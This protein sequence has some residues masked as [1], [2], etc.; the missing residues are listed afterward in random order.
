LIKVGAGEDISITYDIYIFDYQNV[1]EL[2]NGSKPV[3]L[4][5][6]PYRFQEYYYKF[7]ITWSDDGD[8]ATYNT[9]KFYIYN[10]EESGA[11]L[12][13]SDRLTIPYVTILGFEWLLRALPVEVNDLIDTVLAT[14]V[15]GPIEANL[16]E[17]YDS[18][19]NLNPKKKII[20][21]ILTG[22]KTLEPVTHLAIIS[23]WY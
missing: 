2:L 9:Q 18:L 1:N 7:D 14:M 22:I 16:Q 20:G 3:L 13:L 11:G 21:N 10:A 8:T 12:S 5:K 6:G 19:T 23:L 15:F 17:Q 4:Q